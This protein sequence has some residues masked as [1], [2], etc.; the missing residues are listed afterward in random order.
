MDGFARARG[1]ISVVE[2]GV[3]GVLW[4]LWRCGWWNMDLREEGDVCCGCS[5][6]DVVG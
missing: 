3:L 2:V 6:V 1:L 5:F 4:I